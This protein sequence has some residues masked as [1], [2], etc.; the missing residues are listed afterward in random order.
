MTHKKKAMEEEEDRKWK[1]RWKRGTKGQHLRRIAEEPDGKNRTLHAGRAKAHSALLTQLRTGKIG[2]NEFLY[3]RRVPGVWNKR[4]ACGHAA[5]SVRHVLLSCPQWE[6][7]REE[8]LG[9]MVRDLKEVLGTKHGATAAI[10]LT[11]KTGLL[12]QFK[13]TAQARREER[14]RGAGEEQ[15]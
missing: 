5:M 15:G 9:D 11:L 7:E 3:E 10:R 13:A 6:R 2:F 8:E 12:E 14:R 1:E 4:C